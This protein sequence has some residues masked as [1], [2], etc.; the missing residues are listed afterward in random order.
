[1]P[2][3]KKL[4]VVLSVLVTGASTAFFF[5]KDASQLDF[6]HEA[7]AEGPFR[8]RIER[9]VAAD[10]AWSSNPGNGPR[11]Q[12][13]LRVAPATAAIPQG[14]V[15]Q[16]QPT[17]QKSFNPVGAL[18]EPVEG[19]PPDENDPNTS[20]SIDPIASPDASPGLP[21]LTH[22]IVDGD[23]LSKLAAEY[24]GSA[25]RYLEIYEWNRAVLANPDLLPIGKVLRIPPRQAPGAPDG[26]LKSAPSTSDAQSQQLELVPVPAADNQAGS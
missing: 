3:V 17:F 4:A 1:M 8:Q 11:P 23:T 13:A 7:S 9:R 22:K 6:R 18:L 15:S 25:E 16:S 14:L 19:T 26:E 2:G 10:A 21:A 12:Q 5:R 20:N 24:L